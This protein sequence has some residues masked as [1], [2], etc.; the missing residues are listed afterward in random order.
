MRD[1]DN[2]TEGKGPGEEF[3]VISLG[4]YIIYPLI[5]NFGEM[6]LYDLYTRN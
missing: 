3:E 4:L 5:S 6:I 1:R 2:G